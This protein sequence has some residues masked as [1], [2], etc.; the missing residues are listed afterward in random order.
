V[1]LKLCSKQSISFV[2]F[3]LVA[4]ANN[5]QRRADDDSQLKIHGP[6]ASRIAKRRAAKK[7]DAEK[8]E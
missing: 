6:E 4:S 5:I 3:I 7:R 2:L 1:L 8:E